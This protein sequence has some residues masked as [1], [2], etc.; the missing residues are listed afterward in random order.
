MVEADTESPEIPLE[1]YLAYLEK[2]R[3]LS[4]HTIRS[5]RNDLEAWAYWL[6]E[7]GENWRRVDPVCVRGFL[8]NMS[9]RR[10]T[11]SSV[12]R[13]LSSL[14]G[15]YDWAGDRA[16]DPEWGNPFRSAKGL[17]KKRKLP[18]YL[19]AGEFD[20]L[21]EQT[22]EGFAGARDRLIMEVLYS[23][24]CRVSEL[25]SLD[26]RGLDKG[27]VRVM[28]K[29]GKERIVF[30]GEPA[31]KA[32]AAYLPLREKK[33]AEGQDALLLDERGERLTSRGVYYL[34]DKLSV[35]AGLTKRIGP[36]T[37]RH[38]FA[39]SLLN[40]GADIRMVQEMLGHSSLSTTQVYTHT[41]IERMKQVYRRSHPH[42]KI[43]R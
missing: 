3:C 7:Q 29:G 32:L 31:R 41:G 43:R 27:E 34:I 28:G 36:H 5:Y 38:S 19:T 6:G 14:R 1:E 15:F 17:K 24:G 12:N 37:F 33:A 21:L 2:V 16:G 26:R 23:T 11:V 20:S 30:L 4:A 8:A 39:T 42:G 25:C 35:K 22:G 18:T 40:E 9:L 10:M 13:R